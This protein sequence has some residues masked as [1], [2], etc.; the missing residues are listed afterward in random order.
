MFVVGGESLIDLV[1][2]P[3][4]ADGVIHMHAHQGGSPMNCA[5]APV[6]TRQ[7][8]T[9]FLCPISKDRF[10]DYILEPLEAAGVQPLL[11]ERVH[12]ADD[13]CGGD[14]DQKR[15][16]ALRIL[17][18]RRPC[19]SRPRRLIAALPETVAL[20]PDRRL[21]PD[22]AARRGDLARGDRRGG[23]A[24]RD[25]FDRSKCAAVADRRF[26]RLSRPPR[27]V[28]AARAPHQ[29][30]RRGFADAAARPSRSRRMRHSCWPCRRPN[31]WW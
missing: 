3:R 4:G 19:R 7:S 2:E 11:G 21:L 30:V 13:A 1:S 8:T 29:D 17:P 27:R 20:L 24:R 9:G 12:G 14:L 25:D 16:A 10:G 23:A 22:R 31:W 15:Q 6:E 28:L 18:L 5:I 26:R